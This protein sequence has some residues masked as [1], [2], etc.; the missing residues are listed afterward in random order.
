MALAGLEGVT[1]SDESVAGVT[2][3]VVEPATLPDVA[4]IV[5]VPAA[6]QDAR[7]LEPA[8]LL[9]VDTVA[10]EELQVTDA[11]RFCVVPSEYVPVAVN[12]L[13]V[14]FALVGLDG[15]I[16][17]DVSVAGFTVRVVDAN[18]LP[19]VAV[20]VVEPAATDVDRPDA[21]IV[22]TPV[23]DESQPTEAVRFCVVLSEYV[24]VATNCFVVPSAMLGF[25]GVIERD[26]S[27]A[28]FTVRVVDP[29]MVPDVTVIVVVPAVTDVAKPPALIV[30]TPV[31]EEAQV[32]V[33]VRS[34]VVLSENVPVATNCSVVPL[35]MLG[36]TGVIA[37]DTRLVQ[38]TV[39][40]V[41]P[42]LLP[43][44]AQTVVLPQLLPYA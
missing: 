40:V 6:R 39:R 34:C 35:A 32:D 22:A 20:I 25:V 3:S 36:F 12:C 43:D 21:L 31:L 4:V 18:L 23:F 41:E 42:D 29:D 17:M 14:P 19:K 28:G 10:F 15:L 16:E 7:P 26:E 11:V 44:F 24:P 9:I 2:V 8:A 5:E 13:V 38:L 37:M 1:D 30:A 33:N 27:V